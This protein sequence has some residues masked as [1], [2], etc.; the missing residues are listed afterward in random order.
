MFSDP[1]ISRRAAG[2]LPRVVPRPIGPWLGRRN[3]HGNQR[4]FHLGQ[5]TVRRTDRGRAGAPY[6]TWQS[7]KTPEAD[8]NQRINRGLSPIV[9]TCQRLTSPLPAPAHDSVPRRAANP[10]RVEEFHLQCPAGFSRRS[11]CPCSCF[12]SCCSCRVTRG[13]AGRPRKQIETNG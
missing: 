13:K 8:R 5:S 3:P 2:S 10:F 12:C 1:I 4:K 6:H 11:G 9:T 7:G